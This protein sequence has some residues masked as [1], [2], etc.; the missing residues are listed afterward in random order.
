MAKVKYLWILFCWTACTAQP[1]DQ[2]Q[3][4]GEVVVGAQQFN[5][6][7]PK[8]KSK[9]VGV[10]VNHTSLVGK[11]HLVDTL[12]TLG[13]NL[14][15][16]FA[17]EHGFRGTADAGEIINDSI[18]SRTGLPIFSLYGKSKKPTLEHLSGIDVVI[19]DIQDIGVRFFTY[20]STVLYMM[21]AC[22]ENNKTLI[23][24]DRPNPNGGYVDGPVMQPEFR[25]FVG[26]IQIPIVYGMTTGELARLSNEEGWLANKQKC[27]LEVIPLKNWSHGDSYSL[28]IKPSPNLPNDHAI[29]LYPSTCL[30]EGTILSI[31]RGTQNPFEFV[32]HPNLKSYAFN[33]TPISI[34][35]MAKT[36]PLENRVCYGLD[37]RKVTVKKQIDLSYLIE[38]YNAFP[39]KEKFF[40]TYF[41][42]L[43]GNSILKEQIKKGMTEEQ[44]RET[45]QKDLTSFKA[46]RKKYLLYP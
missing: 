46:I 14:K 43:A 30:F 7:L 40:T 2:K 9:K 12:K 10:V 29:A 39:E 19:F 35:G 25:S 27:N 20:I 31:G 17:P 13:V 16:I 5:L 26:L 4:N 24:L 6:L 1:S 11:T 32:G 42:K 8:L 21:E 44:I 36:P 15:K 18:D 23:V 3:S 34:V 28:A 37:L 33:F 45:W 38:L 22:A 41:D